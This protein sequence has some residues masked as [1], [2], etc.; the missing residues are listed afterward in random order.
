MVT[1]DGTIVTAAGSGDGGSA[2]AGFDA[3]SG[4]GLDAMLNFPITATT[5]ASGNLYVADQN[6]HRIRK[7]APGDGTTSGGGDG[8]TTGGDDGWTDDMVGVLPTG[9]ISQIGLDLDETD[10]DQMVRQTPENPV[11]GD[12][13]LVDIFITEG[14]SLV[15]GFS[16][17]LTWDPAEL[18]FV[19]YKSAGAFSGG[20]D[21]TT[22][23]VV[24]AED[25]IAE[26]QTALFFGAPSVDSGT[27]GQATFSVN[28]GFTG[29]ANITLAAAKV[30]S[31][32][33]TIGPGAGHVVIGG[34][35]AVVES[36]AEMANFD[37]DPE[38]VFT[39]FLIFAGGF[40]SQPGDSNFDTRLDLDGDGS[41]G[42]TDFLLFAAVFG[43]IL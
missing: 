6:N 19:S 30:G 38:V 17:T 14:A 11:A 41:V 33:V 7:F 10:G 8:G 29:V 43:T 3:D 42:F 32:D 21:L 1:T 39:D 16:V 4:N 23:S 28:E 31:D 22:P 13:I 15:I 34:N 9:D 20:I 26:L 25:N 27:A 35:V 40:G 24:T 2:S 5:D 18:T 36:P 37:G 12:E